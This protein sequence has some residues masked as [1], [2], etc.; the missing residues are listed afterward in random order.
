MSSNFPRTAPTP[1]QAAKPVGPTGTE[2]PTNKA[3][4]ERFA[5]WEKKTGDSLTPL[6]QATPLR[7]R[8]PTPSKQPGPHASGPA[9]IQTQTSEFRPTGAAR[10]PQNRRRSRSATPSYSTP[11]PPARERTGSCE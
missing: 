1:V 11:E 9:S 10:P 4:A 8:Q 3:V 2:E 6:R 5:M 7:G